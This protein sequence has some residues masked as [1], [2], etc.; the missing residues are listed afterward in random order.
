MAT[1]VGDMIRKRIKEIDREIEGHE[2]ARVEH[3]AAIVPLRGELK[4]LQNGLRDLE[5][6]S[7]GS[8]RARPAVEDEAIVEVVREAQRPVNSHEVA[9]ILGVGVRNVSRKL[10][11][12]VDNGLLAGNAEVGYWFEASESSIERSA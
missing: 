6:I 9:E 2:S 5:R 11:K 1:G 12:L 7:N 8:G 3:K 4:T 10:R